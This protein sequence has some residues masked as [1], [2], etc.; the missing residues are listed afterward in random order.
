MSTPLQG[1]TF[2]SYA[3]DD[4]EFVLRLATA[5]KE[6]GFLIWV[7]QWNIPAGADWDKCIDHALR[8]CGRVVVILSPASIASDEVRGELRTALNARKP[9]LPVLYR[10][11]DIPRQLQLVQYVDLTHGIA[12]EGAFQ[13]LETALRTAGATPAA[14]TGN[15]KQPARRGAARLDELV[16]QFNDAEARLD[17]KIV[18]EVGEEILKHRST[19]ESIR[20]RLALGYRWQGLEHHENKEY[21]AAISAYSRAIDLDPER[22]EYYYLRAQAYGK[23]PKDRQGVNERGYVENLRRAARLSRGAGFDPSAA[24]VIRQVFSS[25]LIGL[26]L[27]TLLGLL[28]FAY[29]GSLIVPTREAKLA[30]WVFGLTI[31]GFVSGFL[32]AGIQR[33]TLRAWGYECGWTPAIILAGLGVITGVLTGWLVPPVPIGE[34]SLVV[35]SLIFVIPVLV[36]FIVSFPLVRRF[37]AFPRLFSE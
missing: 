30:R 28:V 16:V 33:H 31:V 14:S 35:D 17:W 2:V 23:K 1:H 27:W 19:D 3:R 15:K 18:I 13:N 4:Q 11:C 6:R 9:V 36:V 8:D 20:S 32:L 37:A 7:D 24:R 5:L 29:F 22:A 10:H 34:R 21:D 25:D 12:D 26:V